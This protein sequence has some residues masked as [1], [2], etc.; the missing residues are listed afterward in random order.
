MSASKAI[1]RVR[2]YSHNVL[3]KLLSLP[4]LSIILY[5]IGFI[6]SIILYRILFFLCFVLS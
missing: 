3:I 4:A 5:R 2:T 1:F 6:C